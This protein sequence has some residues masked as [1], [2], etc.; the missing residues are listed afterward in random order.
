MVLILGLG[1]YDLI[2]RRRLHPAYLIGL[3]WIV[4][5]QATAITLYHN[6]AWK[7]LAASWIAAA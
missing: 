5:M 3:I 6:A 2:T 7:S 4:A 1:V